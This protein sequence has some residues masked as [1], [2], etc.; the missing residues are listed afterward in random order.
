MR[1]LFITDDFGGASLCARLH[2]EGHVRAHVGNPGYTHPGRL[3]CFIS[4]FFFSA[5][6]EY[7]LSGTLFVQV[8]LIGFARMIEEKSLWHEIEI[9]SRKRKP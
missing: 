8:L 4:P 9:I 1:V 3:E 5:I 2:H 7:L 6:M